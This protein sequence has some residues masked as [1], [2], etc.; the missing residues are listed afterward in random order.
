[1]SDL[2]KDLD[3][4]ARAER[5]LSDELLTEAFMALEDAYIEHWR[6]SKVLDADGREKLW[7]AV[8]IVGKVR[9]HLER[10]INDGKF[11]AAELNKI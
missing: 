7:Q 5:L 1:M 4:A 10:A 8:Q 11:A 9:S 3:R 2:R 6:N